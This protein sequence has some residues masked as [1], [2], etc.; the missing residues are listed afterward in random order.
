[1]ARKSAGLPE[2]TMHV[3][4]A[5][6]SALM[7]GAT[8]YAFYQDHYGRGFPEYQEYYRE[9]ELA[10]LDAQ[11]KA[12]IKESAA[13]PN[14][15]KK[16]EEL[17]VKVTKAEEE[18]KALKAELE[19]LRKEADAEQ[20]LIAKLDRT[21]NAEKANYDELKS[22]IDAGTASASEIPNRDKKIADLFAEKYK[23][24]QA[25]AEILKKIADK[26]AGVAA[27]TKQW[28]T[29][30]S[31][32]N[33]L[34]MKKVKAVGIPIVNIFKDMP[35]LDFIQP[36]L[37]PEQ[38]IIKAPMNVLFAEAPRYDRCVTCHL[39]IDNPD[40]KFA[41][42]SGY[43]KVIQSHPRL[44]LFVGANSPH[45]YEKF[46]CTLCHGGQPAAVDF[47]RAAHSPQNEQQEKYWESQYHWERQEFWDAKMLPLQHVEASCAKCHKGTDEIK[48]ANKLNEG[49]HLFRDKGCVNCHMGSSGGEDMKWVGRV[50]PD[51]R[52]VGEKTNIN[53]AK[54]WIEN[55]WD[56]RPSTKMPRF[57]G[58]ENRKAET[59]DVGG[60]H[61]VRDN[62]EA[63]A[64]AE[65]LFMASQLRDS[66]PTP[67]P[68]G[69]V[70]SGKKI[71]A[72]VGC[73]ACHTTHEAKEEH[74]FEFNQ[75]GPD[76]SRVGEKVSPGW[77]FQWLKNPRHYWAETK[78]PNLRL[79]DKEAADLTS[80][81]MKTMVV[82]TEAAP[83][84]D[85]P[86]EAYEFIIN[87]KL[88]PTT[89]PSKIRER[90]DDP[91]KMVETQLRVKVKAVKGADGT[92]KDTG[93]GEWNEE[94]IGRIKEIIGKQPDPKKSAKAF[95]AGEALI[96]H[97]GCYGCHNIQ[98]WTYAP[99]T[100]PNLNG[101]GDKDL[102][103]LDFGKAHHDHSIAH[104]KWDWFYTKIA[105]PRVFD[106]DKE[107]IIK[108]FDRLRMPWFGYPEKDAAHAEHKEG[109]AKEKADEKKE[110]AKGPAGPHGAGAHTKKYTAKANEDP[111]TAYGLK[112]HE[113]ERLVTLLM[114]LSNEP[115]P[116]DFIARATPQQ[117]AVDRG[118]RVV[119]EL[120][121][122]GC[123]LVSAGGAGMKDGSTTLPL[124]AFAAVFTAKAKR[125]LGGS[126]AGIYS[127]EDL[128]SLDYNS[129]E[130]DFKG[131]IHVK[132]G[133]YLTT[134]GIVTVLMHE[135]KNRANPQ[136]D[137]EP[138]NFRFEKESKG[139]GWFTYGSVVT[140]EKWKSMTKHF[141]EN[142]EDQ[143]GMYRSLASQFIELA[144]YERMAGTNA[145]KIS[146]YEKELRKTQKKFYEP[147]VLKV[148]MTRGEGRIMDHILEKEKEFEN[149]LATS[150]QASPPRLTYEGG[151]VQ[152]DWLYGF[153]HH[154]QPLR[155]GLN[156]RMPSFWMDGGTDFKTVYPAG[157]LSA[158][159]ANKRP[160][161]EALP[162]PDSLRPNEIPDD[163]Q[164]IVDF[165]VADGHEKH[166]GNQPILMTAE[167][168]ALYAQGKAFV[169]GPPDTAAKDGT[170]EKARGVCVT[171]HSVGNFIQK[172]PKYAP[173]LANV[174]RRLREDWVRRFIQAPGTI[175]PGTSM[176]NNF[177]LTWDGY[178]HN[179]ADPFR[180]IVPDAK[181]DPKEWLKTMNAV[182]YFLM[183]SGDAELGV[184]A[185]AP[186]PTPPAPK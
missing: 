166:Y 143:S 150:I 148:R 113:I 117:L 139:E 112:H 1:M 17:K 25:K 174:K 21:L 56:F 168:Q 37:K 97:H 66:A 124:E 13:D 103:K 122:T 63:S 171:C 11:R 12:A 116:A 134:E 27:T 74:K 30:M 169:L 6:G 14:F 141:F 77:L 7:L 186:A 179:F 110:G 29:L 147:I 61:H 161:G 162:G 89:P 5:V 68:Q 109:D 144:A 125:F 24:E 95:F 8:I 81:L 135:L 16:Y 34:D 73:V 62:V 48:G 178:N 87:Q 39:G 153:L 33:D 123:H 59:V 104:T 159:D 172:D 2:P 84:K 184:G 42:F 71:F 64:I 60:A 19:P 136:A 76:L 80:Y 55:P 79:N 31:E 40:P 170:P 127:D 145:L 107:S 138:L 146:S 52:R 155:V 160:K 57:F 86:A 22:K 65:Y 185:T 130:V 165:F 163:A 181:T 78:M 20:I 53:W 23:H 88:E 114:S 101:E 50:G 121:C 152:P 131:M 35:G 183:H 108:P 99:L 75:H 85:F 9:E 72:L 157:R 106:R 156:V 10:S 93:E 38:K 98:G 128:L 177:V 173:N 132:R 92:L 45:P 120:N 36:R 149:P 51:L 119:R 100:C 46:G 151:K 82:K 28:T 4:F 70:E 118:H 129:P 180:G 69:D 96:Q 167:G 83:A 164:Q 105:R 58:L 47:S 137:L 182:R 41:S 102:D 43:K 111:S 32:L 67:P 133:T 140:P 115:V 126:D 18:G 175:S 94:Q 15:V 3:W 158:V 54:N 91:I 154:V 142:E 90:L 26:N 44:D 49:R 176:P